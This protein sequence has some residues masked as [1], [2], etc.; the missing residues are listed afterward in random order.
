MRYKLSNL[1]PVPMRSTYG[2][3]FD[4]STLPTGVT[5]SGSTLRTSTW[6]QWRTASCGTASRPP[7]DPAVGTSSRQ[8]RLAS[9]LG[10]GI[11]RL[12]PRFRWPPPLVASRSRS[13]E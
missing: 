3:R 7:E 4:P 11:L 10:G 9:R 1:M 2:I 5:V 6:W 13:G 12:A 8:P